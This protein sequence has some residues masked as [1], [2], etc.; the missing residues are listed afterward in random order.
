MYG[1][2]FVKKWLI[3]INVSASA[4]SVRCSVGR[5]LIRFLSIVII[6]LPAWP[7]SAED[8]TRS[9]VL[10]DKFRT[11][12]QI[13]RFCGPRGRPSSK[14][15]LTPKSWEAIRKSKFTMKQM[16]ACD[17]AHDALRT[18]RLVLENVTPVTELFE[19]WFYDSD[20]SDL[21]QELYQRHLLGPFLSIQACVSSQK[22]FEE[23]GIGITKCGLRSSSNKQ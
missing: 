6:A 23:A 19:F 22:R 10:R 13:G 4:S 2:S 9:Q 8:S 12:D 17:A 7:S 18:V 20:H 21:S 15:A 11:E 16:A 5:R 14:L 3:K 1:C